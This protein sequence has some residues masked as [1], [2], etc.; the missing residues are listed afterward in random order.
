MYVDDNKA[1]NR[2]LELLNKKYNVKCAYGYAAS[3]PLYMCVNA[4]INP[5][6]FGKGHVYSERTYP[7]GM[8]PN[9]ES[10]MER[11]FLIPFNELISEKDAIEISNRIVEAVR[12]IFN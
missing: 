3:V 7:K 1:R 9:A 4:L 12:E 8:C 10:I 5:K 6:K 11:A 2:L